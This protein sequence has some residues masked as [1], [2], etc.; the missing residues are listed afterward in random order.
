[1]EPIDFSKPLARLGVVMGAGVAA[2]SSN[3]TVDL[4]QT[5]EFDTPAD[6]TKL[7]AA[8]SFTGGVW[9]VSGTHS[10]STDA[11]QATLST[12]NSTADT[13]NTRG[14]IF[15]HNENGRIYVDLNTYPT[16]QSAGFWF[17][18]TA[19]DDG[20]FFYLYGLGEGTSPGTSNI[21]NVQ[22]I[23]S[24]AAYTALL[25][26]AS[27]SSAITISANTRYWATVQTVKNGTCS[28]SIYSTSGSQVGSTVTVAG[29]DLATY[30]HSLG[31]SNS[32][33]GVTHIDDFV[34]DKTD[35]TFPLGP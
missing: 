12:F 2:A 35:G 20:A 29:R 9:A 24:G 22:V 28:L 6:A 19:L 16:T 4:W 21:V 33:T 31:F 13:G 17:K 10:I 18:V 11:E 27:D 8:D 5:F 26:S 30:Y 34:I 15:D 7:N 25:K 3:I 32:S 23:R 14:I 1:M